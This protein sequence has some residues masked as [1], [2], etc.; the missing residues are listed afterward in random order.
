MASAQMTF[1]TIHVFTD[2]G[3]EDTDDELGVKYLLNYN[4]PLNVL[5]VFT[6]S[7]SISAGNAL[8]Y[9]VRTFERTVLSKLTPGTTFAYTTLS[10]YAAAAEN[11]CEYALQIGPLKG[12]D[13]ANM[14]VNRNYVFAG[15]YKTPEGARPSFNRAGSEKILDKFF[16]EGKL[17]DIPSAHMV[18]MRFN[19]DLLS[20]FSTDADDPFASNIVFTAFLLI[21]ARMSPNHVANKFAEG[22]VNPNCGRGAN[23]TSVSKLC[24]ELL[25]VDV[26]FLRGHEDLLNETG[27]CLNVKS[28][29][30]V[31]KNYC[32]E[33]EKNG[34]TL[35]DKEG[36]I[37]SLTD[38]NIML[39]CIADKGREVVESSEAV[40]IFDRGSQGMV[41][42]SDFDVDNIPS[43]LE[44]AWELFKKNAD[45]LTDCFNP[46]YDLFA[47]YVMTGLMAGENRVAHSPE[48]F[49]EKIIHEF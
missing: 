23:F 28:C 25:G 17:V 22:L 13:G 27:S 15:D 41:Y 48:E 6:G 35:K 30:T 8:A 42:V 4:D 7:A 29:E 21:F 36:T 38:V 47:A 2:I 10:D 14:V 31:A 11:C 43:K 19:K 49:L 24:F 16:K 20:K 33:L 39:Q 26:D 45:S 9:W 18:K 32:E 12:Y 40:D 1:P 46:V 3:V 44:N 37:K 34:V 5:I